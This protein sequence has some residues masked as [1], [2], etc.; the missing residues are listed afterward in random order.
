MTNGEAE[1]PSPVASD[2]FQTADRVNAA[3]TRFKRLLLEH[4]GE[5]S[6]PDVQTA[7][8]NLINL[9]SQRRNH[10]DEWSPAQDKNLNSGRWKTVTTPPFPGKLPKQEDDDDER[11]KF[12]LGRMSFGMFKP[13]NSICAVNHIINVVKQLELNNDVNE[14]PKEGADQINSSWEQAYSFEVSMDIL[15]PK[16]GSTIKLP[17]KLVT[18]GVCEPKDATKLGIKFTGGS[19]I[20]DFD[21]SKEENSTLVAMWKEV[22]ENAI[23]K[24]DSQQSY[25]GMVKTYLVHTLMKW[26]MGLDPPVDREDFTQTYVI[27]RPYVGFA[28]IMYIDDDLRITKGNRGTIVVVERLKE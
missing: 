26:M 7:M 28:D 10:P 20:P 14:E 18:N 19:L 5:A 25:F 4:N 22:F 13:T 12:T 21:L 9:A 16:G 27:T 11:T 1:A 15:V 24:E 3:K 17:A 23:S 2:S 8:E 6:H